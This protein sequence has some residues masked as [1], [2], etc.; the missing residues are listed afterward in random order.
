[1][2]TDGEAASIEGA[3]LTEEEEEVSR[4]ELSTSSVSSG[5]LEDEPVPSEN[6]LQA[7]NS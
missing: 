6:P 5:V 1:V 2:R 3:P 7:K 4:L